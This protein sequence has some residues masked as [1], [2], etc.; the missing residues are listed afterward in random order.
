M[1]AA[2][3]ET[4]AAELAAGSGE[5]LR[6]LQQNLGGGMENSARRGKKAKKKARQR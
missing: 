4:G 6:G 1:A 3:T 5:V 2:V